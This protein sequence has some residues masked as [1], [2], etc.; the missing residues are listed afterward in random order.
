MTE[1]TAQNALDKILQYLSSAP[2][3]H[4]K[5]TSADG[6]VLN[7]CVA[8]YRGTGNRQYLDVIKNYMDARISEDGEI[9]KGLAPEQ[10]QDLSRL[11]LGRVLTFLYDGTED[12]KY[13]KAIRRLR[14]LLDTQPRTKENVFANSADAE[15]EIERF[16]QF[17]PFY[18]EYETRWNKKNGYNDICDQYTSA[19]TMYWK[20]A[21]GRYEKDGV[22]DLVKEALFLKSLVDSL[23]VISIQI[24]EDYRLL[25]DILR[26]GIR[27]VLDQLEGA[28]ADG[29][30]LICYVLIKSIR[31]GHISAEKYGR[32]AED[33]MEEILSEDFTAD[34][35]L[36][37]AAM[38]AIAYKLK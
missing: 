7:G 16:S 11:D 5:W 34:K 27:G 24:Y 18:I 4:E 28:G 15:A 2:L 32:I 1:V 10:K 25:E 9:T 30:A 23:D 14:A 35:M 22:F 37:G 3:D 21:A 6:Y 36:A 29:K 17:M 13:L 19:R 26:E 31:R 8:L 20:E 12:E 33:L 38:M